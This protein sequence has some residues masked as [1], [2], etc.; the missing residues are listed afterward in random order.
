MLPARPP[1]PTPRNFP[2]QVDCGSQT[3]M[4]IAESLVGLSVAAIRQKAGSDWVS[5]G[6]G[7][8]PGGGPP[9]AAG[10]A[11]APAPGGAPPPD[12]A[13]TLNSPAATNC[14][15]VMLAFGSAVWAS[16]S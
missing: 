6:A 16:K 10:P 5:A 8:I 12:L 7:P 4:R 2:F 14:T 1:P 15:E 13:G 11:G 3:S 9:A